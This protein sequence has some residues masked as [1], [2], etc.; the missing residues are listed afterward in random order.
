MRQCGHV[1]LHVYVDISV[2]PSF[3][4]M[5]F[6]FF[7]ICSKHDHQ[8]RDS[9]PKDPKR[10]SIVQLIDDFRV[11]GVN[12]ERILYIKVFCSSRLRHNS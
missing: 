1:A 2:T 3:W 12:G 4:S 6:S 7:L 8:V 10:E 11:T 9:D 5:F